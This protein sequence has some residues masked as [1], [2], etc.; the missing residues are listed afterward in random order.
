M[1]KLASISVLLIVS[2]LLVVLS[3][4]VGISVSVAGGSELTS[5]IQ[6]PSPCPPC[7]CAS[8]SPIATA[9]PTPTPTPVSTPAPTPSSNT[10]TINPNT[11]FQTMAGWEATAQA[12]QSDYGD[13]NLYKNNLMDQVVADGIDR[14]RLQVRYDTESTSPN[15][16]VANDNADPFVANPSG[17]QW[18][19][20]N[21]VDAQIEIVN[22][23]RARGV[24]PKVNACY[25][26][27][28]SSAPFEHHVNPEEYAE[29][30]EQVFLRTSKHG[31]VPDYIELLLEADKT[32]NIDW[33]S[34]TTTPNGAKL[35]AVL[36]ATRNRLAAHGWFPKFIAPS[37]T[38]CDKADAFYNAVKKAN[39]TIVGYMG[40]VAYHRY[41]GGSGCT[42]AHVDQNQ[43]IAE[44]DGL[45]VSMLEKI[46]AT[47]LT[48]ITDLKANAVAWQQYTLA[49]DP[50]ITGDN[51]STYY[52]V[53]H[54]THSV[55]IASRM[56][57][58]RQYFKFIRRGAVRIDAQSGNANFNPLAFINPDGK[59]VVPVAS[60]AA[61]SFTLTG[62]PAGRY[63]IKYTTGA[64]YDVDLVDQVIGTGGVI[65]TS[66]PAAGVI[67]VYGK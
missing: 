45:R 41:G 21:G 25:V 32:S 62:L 29:L 63:G 60:L 33:T 3:V 28:N 67:T 5:A 56:K 31:W 44:A 13:W 2:I 64:R 10:I 23:M 9:T 46:G 17:F 4:G 6:E 26:D 57:F 54:S 65:T 48:L 52:L 37:T 49:Y 66:I 53:N 61:G 16:V 20:K 34:S 11:R 19:S 30:W 47:Y 42:Q 22:M 18:G 58:L 24:I 39:P 59:Y 38:L 55:T 36:I 27:F 1:R 15:G 14:L 35:A 43:S 12:G 7:P 8:P 40:E 50:A 51:G